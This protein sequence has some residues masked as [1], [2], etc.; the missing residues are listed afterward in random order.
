M[1]MKLIPTALQIALVVCAAATAQASSGHPLTI[2]PLHSKMTVYVYKEGFFSFAGDDH[3]VDAPIASGSLDEAGNKV[4]VT[5]DATKMRVLDPKFAA[6]K[7]AKVQANMT[8]PQ[9]LDVA[10]YPTIVFQ[11]REAKFTGL[12][13]A[14]INGTLTLHGQTHAIAVDVTKVDATHYRGSAIV[15]QTA[16]GIAPIRIA[17]GLVRVKDDVKLTFEIALH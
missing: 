4:D 13:H 16:F 11:S 3:V 8:G 15:R 17:G 2:D 6:D 1:R 9:V 7:R 14:V 10:R 5:I 12:G